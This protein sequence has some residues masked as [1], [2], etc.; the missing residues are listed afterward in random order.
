[1][2][3]MN[4]TVLFA[5]LFGAAFT[6]GAFAQTPAATPADKPPTINQ[7]LENQ[8]D[9]TRAGT[10]DGQLTKGERTHLHAAD[11]SIRAQERVYRRAN[12]GRL[13]GGERRQLNREL[14]RTSRQ[15]YR[16]RHNNRNPR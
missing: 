6:S 8:R 5:A 10:G 4:Q 16:D 9:R 15:I 13:S 7:R 2:S 3:H 14:N 12:D 11:A 1:M